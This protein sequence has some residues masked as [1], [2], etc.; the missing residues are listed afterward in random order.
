[1]SALALSTRNPQPI[2]IT[3]PKSL[4]SEAYRNI[5]TNIQFSTAVNDMRTVMFTS[6]L[7][8]EGKT[9]TA[10]NVAV[11]SA[12]A[13]KRVLLVDADLRK[14][15]VH[16]RFQVSNLDGL[17]TVLI[18]ERRL[19]ECIIESQ[20]HN[21]YLLPSGPIPPNPSEML[22][23][24]VFSALAQ[25]C[26]Q[27]YDVVIFDTPPVL[28]VTDALVV[29][30]LAD[31]VVFVVNARKTNRNLARQAVAA[32][33]QVNA[34]ILGVVLNRVQQRDRQYGYT[35]SYYYASEEKLSM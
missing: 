14:P 11:V 9:S 8:E 27:E 35:Y 24:R 33:Q 16:H 21:L 15:Q 18:R 5:R 7:P 31:G 28:S 1:M 10:S 32:L 22:S 17:S 26:A 2:T 19:E 12:Q 6:T 29:S 13:G 34:R 4:I 23:S 3:Q 25:H 20:V 30:Q